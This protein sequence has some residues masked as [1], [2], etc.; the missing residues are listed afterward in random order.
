MNDYLARRDS[1]WVGQVHRFLGLRVG[2]VQQGL[3]E[4]ERKAAYRSDITYVTNSELGFDYLRDNLA[5]ARAAPCRRCPGRSNRCASDAAGV[6]A[7]LAVFARWTKSQHACMCAPPG[8]ALAGRLES[9]HSCLLAV[10][11]VWGMDACGWRGRVPQA[12]LKS[13]GVRGGA[14]GG[15]PGADGVCVL[16]DRRG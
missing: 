9:S 10:M 12:A 6:V 14:E 5:Q 1:E 3:A 8:T 16:R 13:S 2:L 15:G 11:C 4:A 7:I